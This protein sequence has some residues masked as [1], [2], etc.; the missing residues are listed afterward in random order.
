MNDNRSNDVGEVV[1]TGTNIPTVKK[2]FPKITINCEDRD[3]PLI[4]KDSSGFV[5]WD[6]RDGSHIQDPPLQT[7]END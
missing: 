3:Y 2:A 6:N 4:C 1:E 7:R 5:Y